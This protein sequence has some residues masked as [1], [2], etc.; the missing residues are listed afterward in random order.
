MKG[1]SATLAF[2]LL[3]GIAVLIMIAA[4]ARPLHALGYETSVETVVY[5]ADLIVRGRVIGSRASNTTGVY[6]NTIQVAE[7]LLGPAH[8]EVEFEGSAPSL[9]ER[10]EEHLYS[11]RIAP[12]LPGAPSDA[13]KYLALYWFAVIP[14]SG[15]LDQ[16]MYSAQL[17]RVEQGE[18]VQG[19]LRE[20]AASRTSREWPSF[21]VVYVALPNDAGYREWRN[22]SMPFS[23]RTVNAAR[24]MVTQPDMIERSNG[25]AILEAAN[26][27]DD[28]ELL[29]AMLDDPYEESFGVGKRKRIEY[30]LRGRVARML[31]VR[32]APH[33]PPV[34]TAP[35]DITG[36]VRRSTIA[37]VGGAY[38][39]CLV[40]AWSWS[41]PSFWQPSFT[42]RML[43]RFN[44][45]LLVTCLFMGFFLVRSFW[46]VDQFIIGRAAQ[47]WELCLARGALCIWRIQDLPA[48]PGVQHLAYPLGTDLDSL[49][50]IN[51]SSP[52]ATRH[53]LL[54]IS[55]RGWRTRG[56]A[57]GINYTWRALSF[58]AYTIFGAPLALI[59]LHRMA[60]VVIRRRLQR[61]R[62]CVAC[63]YDLRASPESCPECGTPVGKTAHGISDAER[64]RQEDQHNSAMREYHDKL[65][66]ALGRLA[67]R[68][69]DPVE[70]LTR[71]EAGFDA[72][73]A[74][75]KVPREAKPAAAN[76]AN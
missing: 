41:S 13:P 35:R 33:S 27:P 15:P 7:T 29:K 10:R 66:A 39:V 57:E 73:G 54:F 68:V 51:A 17:I 9:R 48:A 55:A 14:A 64:K 61:R 43:H 67:M 38:A 31:A 53:W 47:R 23:G 4:P 59:A 72:V 8:K 50:R 40:L 3:W 36:P 12:R 26:D 6:Y 56:A 32:Q 52:D 58:P 21:K 76:D 49:W 75:A 34:L 2:G 5:Y 65:A 20:E 69:Q 24:R 25:L 22:L 18:E 71:E 37:T 1:P 28:N 11:L 62:V 19:L 63:G 46:R 16:A 30:P 70:A 44:S 60:G 74:E 45:I 42:L